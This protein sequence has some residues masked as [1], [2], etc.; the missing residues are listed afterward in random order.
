MT[1][2][3]EGKQQKIIISVLR[4]VDPSIYVSYT[5][6]QF[7]TDNVQDAAEEMSTL[8]HGSEPKGQNQRVGTSFI[9]FAQSAL[10]KIK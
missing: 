3:F 6:S 2:G 9:N 7:V 5:P 10:P 8:L 1:C 4:F